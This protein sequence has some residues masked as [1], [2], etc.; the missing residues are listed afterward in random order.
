[1][2]KKKMVIAIS[3]AISS[4]IYASDLSFYAGG[5]VQ[6]TRLDAHYD[7]VMSATII[8]QN[9]EGNWDNVKAELLTIIQN[10]VR[11]NR[12]Y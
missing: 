1:M 11:I 6:N 8:R 12:S 10:L 7:R 2:Q 4:P 9:E 5:A 3:L